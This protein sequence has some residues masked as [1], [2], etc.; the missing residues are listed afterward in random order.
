MNHNLKWMLLGIFL[1]VA[2]IWCLVYGQGEILT[3]I[4]GVY[5]LPI[6]AVICFG[7]GFSG[8]AGEDAQPPSDDSS[9]TEHHE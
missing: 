5:V 2:A 9:H 1:G 3:S 8:H 4:L 6:V 7:T